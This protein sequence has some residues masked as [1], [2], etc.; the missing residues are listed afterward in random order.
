[1]GEY[2][3]LYVQSDPTQLVDILNQFRTLSLHEYKL[4]PAYYCTTL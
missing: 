3:D 2:H 4:D 1:M